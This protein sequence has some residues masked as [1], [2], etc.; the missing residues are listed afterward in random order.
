MG[1]AARSDM[2]AEEQDRSGPTS[3]YLLAGLL[4][5]KQDGEALVGS[6][7]GKADRP[8]RIYRHKRAARECLSGSIY[9][10][11]FNAEPLEQAVLAV[12]REILLDW[13]EFESRLLTHGKAP[14]SVT[15]ATNRMFN[16]KPEAP[17]A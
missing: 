1:A 14:R 10:K 16:C 2:G 7:S 5:A 8:V 12:L 11:V 13:P 17:A 6:S 9:N 4:I 15:S 3:P